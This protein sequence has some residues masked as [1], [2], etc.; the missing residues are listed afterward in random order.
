MTDRQRELV[1]VLAFCLGFMLLSALFSRAG[2]PAADQPP[3]PK[4]RHE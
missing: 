4:D 1:V 2:F 3:I